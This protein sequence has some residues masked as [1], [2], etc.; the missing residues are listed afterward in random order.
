MLSEIRKA[1]VAG[2]GV[3]LSFLLGVHDI[4]SFLP[5]SV[6]IWVGAAIAILTPIATYLVPNGA[7]TTTST[8]PPAAA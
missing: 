3:A 5:A 8:T 7:A 2:V 4:S 6:N 1:V